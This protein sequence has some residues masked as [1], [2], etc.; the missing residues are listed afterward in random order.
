MNQQLK[1]SLKKLRLSGIAGSIEMRLHE[2]MANQ[3][4]H[5][6]FLEL[7]LSDELAVREDR[8]LQRRLKAAQ[9]RQLKRIEDF[10]FS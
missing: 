8:A 9:F 5:A 3:L 4:S 2:A 1:L 10:D 7:I 6:E